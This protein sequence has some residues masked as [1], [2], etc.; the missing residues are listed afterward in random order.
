M[1][2]CE[3]LIMAKENDLEVLKKRFHEKEEEVGLLKASNLKIKEE[4]KMMKEIFQE[5]KHQLEIK[6]EDLVV[7]NQL[8][9]N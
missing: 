8:L 2:K 1:S 7:K 5:F 9:E 4:M 6:I 3:D